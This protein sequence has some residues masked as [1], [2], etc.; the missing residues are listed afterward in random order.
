MP[1]EA[2][3][4]TSHFDSTMSVNKH[5]TTDFG[6]V[7]LMDRDTPD[8]WWNQRECIDDAPVVGT[9]RIHALVVDLDAFAPARW[10]HESFPGSLREPDFYDD[11][12]AFWLTPDAIVSIDVL[13]IDEIESILAVEERIEYRKDGLG[14]TRIHP[15]R[16][17]IEVDWFN[18][19]SHDAGR[20]W[21]FLTQAIKSVL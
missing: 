3:S 18:G 9:G 12:K 10:V 15:S 2:T 11:G 1:K 8:L 17:G 16:Y 6:Q 5:N 19:E 13:R 14:W 7:V 4:M 20:A 21:W